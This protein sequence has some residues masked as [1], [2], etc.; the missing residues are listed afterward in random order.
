MLLMLLMRDGMQW[1][2]DFRSGIT[3]LVRFKLV[4]LMWRFM[5]MALSI[6]TPFKVARLLNTRLKF[7][8]LTKS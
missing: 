1:K 8:I 2:K 3:E 5:L 6:T 4:Q 7:H